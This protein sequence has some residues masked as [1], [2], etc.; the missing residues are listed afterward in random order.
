MKKQILALILFITFS[1]QSN[2]IQVDSYGINFDSITYG[3]PSSVSLQSDNKAILVTRVSSNHYRVMR[4]NSDSSIDTSFNSF[5]VATSSTT[6]V[7]KPFILPNDKIIIYGS[8][9]EF[10]GSPSHGIARLDSNGNTDFLFSSNKYSSLSSAQSVKAVALDYEGNLLISRPYGV[11]K[12]DKTDQRDLNFDLKLFRNGTA[13]SARNIIPRIDGRILL[14]HNAQWVTDSQGSFD[15]NGITEFLPTGEPLRSISVE[16]DL[17]SQESGVIASASFISGSALVT[18]LTNSGTLYNFAKLNFDNSISPNFNIA[19]PSGEYVTH[20]RSVI[21]IQD[22]AS[23]I[24][25]IS[26][27]WT[28]GGYTIRKFHP[29]GSLDTTFNMPGTVTSST[30]APSSS[31]FGIQSTAQQS[32]GSIIIIGGFDSVLGASRPGIA[33]LSDDNACVSP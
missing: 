19:I 31:G 21:M 32:D 29:D 14:A 30:Y 7:G 6:S 12:W 5:D 11:E 23:I 24:A 10:R 2:A 28:A 8:F 27:Y 9:R 26:D 4:L 18:R 3:K 13:S 1:C 17:V 16:N 20:R 25:P 22:D 15:V 33:R